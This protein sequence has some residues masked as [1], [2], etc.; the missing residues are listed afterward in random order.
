MGVALA[1]DLKLY[2]CRLGT[3]RYSVNELKTKK[4]ERHLQDSNL[5]SISPLE[6]SNHISNVVR[7]TPKEMP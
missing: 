3:R 2:Y 5:R 1:E 4:S 7:L 6:A